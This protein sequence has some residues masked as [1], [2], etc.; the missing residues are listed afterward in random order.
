MIET[1]I[2]KAGEYKEVQITKSGKYVVI[3][4]GE[5]AGVEVN[6]RILVKSSD[7]YKVEL[8]VHHLA[9]DTTS[10]VLLKAVGRDRAS[11][12]LRGKIVIDKNCEGANA[13]LTQRVLT[14][15][16]KAEVVS[17]PE[18]EILTN[19][20]ICSHA[21]TVSSISNKQLEYLMSRGLN[22]KEAEELVVEGF[23]K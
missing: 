10:K 14:L 8:T 5:G 20:V 23:L 4:E 19:A 21:S 3:L 2:V 6:G 15:S 1:T 11:V 13:K 7:V 16:D 9:K 18:L 12:E 22:K 17:A